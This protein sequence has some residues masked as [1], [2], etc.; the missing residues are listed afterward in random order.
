MYVYIYTYI[1]TYIHTYTCTYTDAYT[2]AQN[3]CF[4]DAPGDKHTT[5]ILTHIH[6]R[7]Y[8]HSKRINKHTAC[9]HMCMH[10]Y[11]PEVRFLVTI[12]PASYLCMYTYVS[13]C[14]YACVRV[15]HTHTHTLA[16][17]PKTLHA[18]MHIHRCTN[19]HIH[20]YIHT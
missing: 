12:I 18:Y 13:L 5:S 1:Y 8:I 20:T 2:Y 10:T 15:V 14:V 9:T 11:T 4:C 17:P 16:P 6:R 19:M 7:V 3:L